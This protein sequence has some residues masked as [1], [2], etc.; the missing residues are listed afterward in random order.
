[1]L[2][3]R[4]EGVSQGISALTSRLVTPI[5]MGVGAESSLLFFTNVS[6]FVQVTSI[7]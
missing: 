3:G 4:P 5:L 1:M 7:R 2:I 6:V